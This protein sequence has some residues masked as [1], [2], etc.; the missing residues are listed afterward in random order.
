MR[1]WLRRIAL[2][3]LVVVGLGLLGG[4]WWVKRQG[5]APGDWGEYATARVQF[6]A[7]GIPTLRGA[8]Q[9][10]TNQAHLTQLRWTN[11]DPGNPGPE[12]MEVAP[13]WAE[14]D[15]S[16][17]NIGCSKVRGPRAPPVTAVV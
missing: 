14:I 13:V 12:K 10:G 4:A 11:Q 1:P 8:A 17:G 2:T 3:L 9:R 5:V 7:H 16:A 6:D 15:R